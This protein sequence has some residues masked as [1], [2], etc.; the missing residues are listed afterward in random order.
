[1]ASDFKEEVEKL[2][3]DIKKD[4]YIKDEILRKIVSL[5]LSIKERKFP[6]T[7]PPRGL[8]FYG[9][10]GTGKTELMRTLVKRLNLSEPIIVRGPE[11]ISQYYGKSEARLR[12]IFE[13]AK[14][15]AEKENLAV[16]FIDEI[17]AIAPRRDLV[18]GELEPR[19]VSQLLTLMDG[20]EREVSK[21]KEKEGEESKDLEE[22]KGHVIVIGSTNR[23]EALD[24]ALR[25][26][27]RFDLEIEFDPPNADERAK[28]FNIILRKYAK[29][30]YE[31]DLESK[32]EEI[33][34]QTI[35]FTGADLLQLLNESFLIA[36]MEGR[37]KITYQ[38]VKNAMKNVK[39]S[40]L[41]EFYVAKPKDWSNEINKETLDKI[42]MIADDFIKKPRFKAILIS[43]NLELSDK[44]ASTLAFIL[45]E[46]LVQTSKSYPYIIVSATWF[47]SRWFGEMER[48]I[49]EVF[50]KLKRSQPS[51]VYIKNFDAI[52]IRNEHTY[53]AILEIIDNLSNFKVND[54]QILMLCSVKKV[55]KID[56]EIISYF[57]KPFNSMKQSILLTKSSLC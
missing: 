16:I 7:K 43:G 17:D 20:L 19:L 3:E 45:N 34:E 31:K 48:S 33:G 1:M 26:P 35:G 39:P 8:L 14:E 32:L 37:S 46:K 27:G 53:G 50:S 44:L 22:N 5:F 51:I 40:A 9:P 54:V 15:K 38:D 24:P 13:Q 23:P 25:R 28:I 49:R 10:P 2:V 12:Q 55:N 11:I 4:V 6:G 57:E 21:T 36:M 18:K 42:F 47:R 41:R 30:K 29:D 56:K 52:A